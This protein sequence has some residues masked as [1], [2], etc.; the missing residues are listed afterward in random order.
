MNKIKSLLIYILP[1]SGKTF[2]L[3]N[4]AITEILK[5]HAEIQML[6]RQDIM[7]LATLISK[8]Q[9]QPEKVSTEPKSLDDEDIMYK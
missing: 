9:Q 8:N 7:T 3:E 4:M 6:N 2:Y 5:A 1:V